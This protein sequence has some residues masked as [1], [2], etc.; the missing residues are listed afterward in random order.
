MVSRL[1]H[2]AKLIDW[3]PQ[4]ARSTTS[5]GSP[6]NRERTKSVVPGDRTTPLDPPIV[7]NVPP[8]AQAP[9]HFSSRDQTHKVR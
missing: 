6:P 3:P 2:I 1:T 5:S 7:A 8:P 9:Q 4:G